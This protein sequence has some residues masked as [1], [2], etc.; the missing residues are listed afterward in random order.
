[1][2]KRILSSIVGVTLLCSLCL[3]VLIS[4]QNS[5]PV[6]AL[7]PTELDPSDWRSTIF[8]ND[9]VES[10]HQSF[11]SAESGD[12]MRELEYHFISHV[13]V[14]GESIED[15][16]TMMVGDTTYVAVR[17]MVSALFPLATYT[18][19]EELLIISD[20]SFL[21]E[22]RLGDLYIS[23][24][25]RY[26]YVPDGI[27]LQDGNTMLP[28]RIL[29]TALGATTNWLP[30]TGDIS[31]DQTA[32]PVVHGD[33]YY[34]EDD[35]YW[36]SRIISAESK[37]QPL[38]GK[39]GVGTVI[40]NR[41]ESTRYPDNIKDVIFQTNQFTPAATGSVYNT[42]TEDSIIA[43]KLVLDGARETGDSIFFNVV[44]LDSW[45]ANTKTYVT[46]IADH[47]FYR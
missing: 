17:D 14:N 33:L 47:S 34:N 10:A 42:P 13:K 26:F 35:L 30:M 22:A 2:Q 11:A 32:P 8:I 31:I 36:L 25:E 37:N 18:W 43:A 46:T 45:A 3:S 6:S 27:F 9:V 19:E 24:N 7:G 44:G 29:C 5:P 28:L 12:A 4:Y 39:I 21:L 23:V 1:M 41:V 38:A 16:T 40:M 20:A 15:P